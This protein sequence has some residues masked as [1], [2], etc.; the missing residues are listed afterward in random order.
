MHF[1]L[2][3]FIKCMVQFKL[4]QSFLGLKL[5]FI[6]HIAIL[7]IFKHNSLFYDRYVLKQSS[8]F[9]I[10]VFNSSSCFVIVIFN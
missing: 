9:V 10:V 5:T 2:A 6:E 8:C 7:H 4:V 3:L 1:H